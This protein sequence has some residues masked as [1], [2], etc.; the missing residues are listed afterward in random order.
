[1]NSVTARAAA[2]ASSASATART[3]REP[4]ITPSATR[5]DLADLLGGADPEADRDRHRR[6]GPGRLD[7][8][9]EPAAAAGRA[10]RWSGCRRP[11]RRSPPRRRRSARGARAG[12][13]GR[14]AGTRASPASRSAAAISSPPPGA[15][16][17]RSRPPAPASASR[18]GEAFGAARER[19]VGVGHRRRPRRAPRAARRSRAP[20]RARRPPRAPPSRRRGS[21]ARRRA[22]RRTGSRARPGRRPRRR[23]RR[24]PRARSRA[25]G[26]PPIMYGISAA[27][28]CPRAAAKAA[29]IALSHPRAARPPRRGPC[30]RGRRASSRSLGPSIGNPRTSAV[31]AGR[32]RGVLQQ[33][34][35]RV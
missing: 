20:S 24:R 25:S 34:G 4:T 12:W 1:M 18:A 13:S 9:G 21:P 23:R 35:D 15:G 32:W 27:R 10:R 6:V 11:G 19:H 8:L 7:Q 22:G 17:E 16:R 33:P 28:P 31:E 5:A 3:S 2:S 30:H 26:K 14:P 29:A